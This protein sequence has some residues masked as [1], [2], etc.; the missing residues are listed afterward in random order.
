[1][2]YTKPGAL[3]SSVAS[4]SRSAWRDDWDDRAGTPV[5]EPHLPV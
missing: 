2:L 1:M 3:L 5:E 4:S